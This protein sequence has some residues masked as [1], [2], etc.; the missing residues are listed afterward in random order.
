MHKSG[1]C[2]WKDCLQTKEV[3]MRLAQTADTGKQ[4]SMRTKGGKAA[5]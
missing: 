3:L 5:A 4:G 1:R 2:G